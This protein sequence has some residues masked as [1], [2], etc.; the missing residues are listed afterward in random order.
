MA[1]PKPLVYIVDDHAPF[2]D[3]LRRMLE[4][5]G[6]AVRE[7]ES[8]EAFLDA[9]RQAP[10]GCAMI[11][12]NMPGMNGL[13][14]QERLREWGIGLPVIIMT[15][16]ADVPKAVRAMKAGAV[17]FLE[18]P[19]E[20]TAVVDAITASQSIVRHPTID[21]PALGAFRQ[22]L[23]RLTDRERQVLEAV[24]AGNTSKMIALEL[25]ISPQT[26]HVHRARIGDK[27]GVSGLSNLVRLA[28]AAGVNGHS[29]KPHEPSPVVSSHFW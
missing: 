2:R 1:A 28:L 5:T 25:G 11:D 7:F 18:K 29:A 20:L 19:L 3:S 22:N 10:A 8:A 12:V 13:A 24:V 16:Q 4:A 21:D 9:V 17:D 6:H 27:L 23:S 26:V 15:G 14:L